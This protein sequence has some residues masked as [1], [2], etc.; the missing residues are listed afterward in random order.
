MSTFPRDRR[1]SNPG[2][3]AQS[4]L[5]LLIPTLREYLTIEEELQIHQQFLGN[6]WRP[7]KQ[8]LWSGMAREEAQKWA[9]KHDMQTLTTAMGPLMNPSD[10]LCLKRKKSK[11]GWA[12]YIKGASA[13][14]AWHISRGKKVTVLSPPPPQRFHPSGL[15]TYQAVEEPILKRAIACGAVLQIDM[16]HPTVKG[17]ENFRYQIWPIDQTVTWVAAFQGGANYKYRWRMVKMDAQ[18]VAIKKGIQESKRSLF[19]TTPI[20]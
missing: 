3:V 1:Q 2:N 5:S 16:V 15:T 20:F 6:Q 12:R 4:S 11:V 13:L 17:A 19:E 18:Q 9:D 10:P 8:V 7:N 14:F